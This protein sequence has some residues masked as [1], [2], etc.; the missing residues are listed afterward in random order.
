MKTNKLADYIV[1]T[2]TNQSFSI[3]LTENI[4][5]A[6]MISY[7]V[8]V[9]D[10]SADSAW[11][12]SFFETFKSAEDADAYIQNFVDDHNAAVDAG[13]GTHTV[14]VSER[15]TETGLKHEFEL[16]RRVFSRRSGF[17]DVTY[18]VV[19]S[20]GEMENG[21]ICDSSHGYKVIEFD[22]FAAARY[23][24]DYYTKE[25]YTDAN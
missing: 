7:V 19:H 11:D 15:T 12:D 6:D 20:W 13:C 21:E 10:L 3:E 8:L 23:G 18:E 14:E 1:K 5:A 17:L 16:V 25:E 22:N 9:T 24:F 2:D 4:I